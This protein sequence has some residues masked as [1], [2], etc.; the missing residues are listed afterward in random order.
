MK[1]A[2]DR[3]RRSVE[4]LER[5]MDAALFQFIVKWNKKEET[6]RTECAV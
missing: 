6:K 4:E 2:E 1:E 3:F 5:E